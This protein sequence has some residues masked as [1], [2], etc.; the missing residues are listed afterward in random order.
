M[1]I[2]DDLVWQLTPKRVPKKLAPSASCPS[3]FFRSDAKAKSRQS[4][5]PKRV[6]QSTWPLLGCC[7]NCWRAHFFLPPPLSPSSLFSQDT[8]LPSMTTPLPS[9]KATRERPSQF[10]NVSHT[11]GC[12]GWN[13]H[14]AISLDF[15]E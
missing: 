13:E 1:N 4:E 5:S 7:H 11:N 2:N 12:C 14:S 8:T 3:P 9:M 15:K 6:P 10:L